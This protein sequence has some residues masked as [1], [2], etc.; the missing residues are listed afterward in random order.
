MRLRAG[1]PGEGRQGRQ[2]RQAAAVQ[3]R[4]GEGGRGRQ[5][6]RAGPGPGSHVPPDRR[7]AGDHRRPHARPVPHRARTAGQ[8]ELRAG[9]RGRVRHREDRHPG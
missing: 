8:G 5:G 6:Q 7:Q 9:H 3:G 4:P 2:R 1:H